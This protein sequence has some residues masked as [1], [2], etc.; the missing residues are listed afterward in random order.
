M[1]AP[2]RVVQITAA[3]ILPDRELFPRLDRVGGLPLELRRRVEV[4]LRDPWLCTRELLELGRALAGRARRVGACLMV[5]DRL[6]VAR[7][8]DAD[9]AHL[10]SR[11]VAVADARRLLGEGARISVACHSVVEVAA[12]RDA[13]ADAALLSPVF[14]APGKGR[15]LG[16]GALRQARSALGPESPLELI[17]L[18]GV[19]PERVASCLQA[20]AD[21]VAS[22]RADLLGC[23]SHVANS[24]REH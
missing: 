16:L 14:P 15:P 11:S 1:S 21:G 19:S 2:R 17:A 18:G 10:G 7:L 5:N 4:Q 12:A 8:L 9:G 6:D 20:G 22:I 3:D 24:T 23:L 13:G